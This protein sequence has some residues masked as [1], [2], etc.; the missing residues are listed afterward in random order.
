MFPSRSTLAIALATVSLTLGSSLAF[1][2]ETAT[3]PVIKSCSRLPAKEKA[4]CEWENH[5]AYKALVKLQPAVVTV[6]P[7]PV[8]NLAASLTLRSCSRLSGKEKATC[9]WENHKAV[10]NAKTGNKGSAMSAASKTSAAASVAEGASASLRTSDTC[11]IL[12]GRTR[13]QCMLNARKASRG[14]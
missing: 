2:A 9:E 6:E 3:T 8:S 7:V 10:V 4:T 12:K 5:K 11:K 13:A 14:Q 1:A